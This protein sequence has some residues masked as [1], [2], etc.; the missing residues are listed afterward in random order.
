VNSL[1]YRALKDRKTGIFLQTLFWLGSKTG[2]APGCL[3]LWTGT[4]HCPEKLKA[5]EE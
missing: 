2:K 1:F 4:Y 3:L 5:R